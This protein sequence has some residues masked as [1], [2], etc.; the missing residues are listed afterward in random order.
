MDIFIKSF[1]VTWPTRSL[2]KMLLGQKK[3]EKF[4]HISGY[5]FPLLSELHELLHANLLAEVPGIQIAS[6]WAYHRFRWYATLENK[7]TAETFPKFRSV[8]RVIDR[9]DRNPP[10]TA[11]RCDLLTFSTSCYRAV[12]GGFRSDLSHKQDWRKFWKRFRGQSRINENGG[13][14]KHIRLDPF[15]WNTLV[16]TQ[17]NSWYHPAIHSWP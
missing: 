16:N 17:I 4:V 2:V 5:F 15:R 7:T 12:I 13:S 10:I 9:S 14:L 11:T 1:C 6:L 8:L 3:L